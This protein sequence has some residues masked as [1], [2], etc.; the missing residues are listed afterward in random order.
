[1]RRVIAETI[2]VC[3]L[4]LA[5]WQWDHYLDRMEYAAAQERFMSTIAADMDALTARAQA[6]TTGMNN[7]WQ[8]WR[9]T[10]WQER[11]DRDGR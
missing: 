5:L 2:L 4:V 1:M 3:V 8:A 10:T 7:C 6:I 11:W 9:H